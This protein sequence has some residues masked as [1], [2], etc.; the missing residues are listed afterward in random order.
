MTDHDITVTPGTIW[1]DLLTFNAEYFDDRLRLE[2]N[3]EKK[4][5]KIFLD[6]DNLEV[7]VKFFEITN[8]E[9]EEDDE[10]APKRL[11][12]RLVKKRGNLN[13]WYEL[14]NDLKD[15]VFEETLLSNKNHIDEDL[16]NSTYET[17]GEVSV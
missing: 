6:D 14:F 2:Q 3:L 13:Q 7:K 1:E 11:R 8:S 4:C 15:T 5:F 17:C 16:T 10:E 9:E 12:M